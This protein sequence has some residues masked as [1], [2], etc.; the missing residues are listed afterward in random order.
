MRA[1]GTLSSQGGR[2]VTVIGSGVDA[3]AARCAAY[4]EVRELAGLLAYREDIGV[5]AL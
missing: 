2:I 1:D 5:R 4:S 3:Y